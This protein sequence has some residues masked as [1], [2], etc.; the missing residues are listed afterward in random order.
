MKTKIIFTT[1]P[2]AHIQIIAQN[3][4]AQIA[5]IVP[6][7]LFAHLHRQN[8]N[9]FHET[10]IISCF[11]AI[12]V[13]FRTIFQT[14]SFK[15][16]QKTVSVIRKKTTKTTEPRKFLL[17]ALQQLGSTLNYIFVKYKLNF[18]IELK[19]KY[20]YS[21]LSFEITSKGKLNN[22]SVELNSNS[23]HSFDSLPRIQQKLFS[24]TNIISFSLFLLSV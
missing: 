4:I 7:A 17:R 3:S 6:I 2:I 24:V 19:T 14:I 16:L 13:K 23:L 9:S 22:S 20:Y 1:N 21:E 12:F 10:D 15:S 18:Q 5:H 11:D 8:Q